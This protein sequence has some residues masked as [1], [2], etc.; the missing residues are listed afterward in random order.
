M[1]SLEEDSR[2]FLDDKGCSDVHLFNCFHLS[3]V[4]DFSEPLLDDHDLVKHLFDLPDA[5][6]CEKSL[7]ATSSVPPPSLQALSCFYLIG[8]V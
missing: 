2:V 1:Q 6:W 4:H 5:K 3:L 8:L 7:F